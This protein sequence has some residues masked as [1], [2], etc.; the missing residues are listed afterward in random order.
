MIALYKSYLKIQINLYNSL[1]LFVCFFA[2]NMRLLP[3]YSNLLQIYLLYS[4]L[5][6]GIKEVYR[7]HLVKT[8]GRAYSV[9]SGMSTPR[10]ISRGE[11]RIPLKTDAFD[12]QTK[13]VSP[14]RSFARGLYL[15]YMKVWKYGEENNIKSFDEHSKICTQTKVDFYRTRHIILFFVMSVII[16]CLL[17][18]KKK[19]NPIDKKFIISFGK[20]ILKWNIKSVVKH[21]GLRTLHI[22]RI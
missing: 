11:N 6:E 9:G 14:V 12:S 18:F 17:I 5:N 20:K 8:C 7:Q 15:K 16:M 13:S 22:H 1:F 21:D 4:V 3:G 19:K 2:I 10:K